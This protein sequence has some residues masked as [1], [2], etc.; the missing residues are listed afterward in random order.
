MNKIINFLI[1]YAGFFIVE[2]VSCFLILF[3]DSSNY[4]SNFDG[5][6]LWNLWRVLFYGVPFVI[7]Y[8]LLSKY[9]GNINFY[10]PLLFSCFNLLIYVFLSVLSRVIWGKNVPLPPE[11]IMFWI[12]VVSIFIA[13]IILGQI[14]YFRR[15]M[16]NI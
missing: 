9:I 1:L 4:E 14:P 11:G 2:V 5:T 13:P 15:L 12:T 16:E 8:F 10:K 3:F 6:V 7:L